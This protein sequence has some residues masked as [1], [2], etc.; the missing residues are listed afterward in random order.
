MDVFELLEL[1]VIRRVLATFLQPGDWDTAAAACL[2]F[3]SIA[4]VHNTGFYFPGNIP[5]SSY[6]FQIH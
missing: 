1:I 5:A 4:R 6:T 3:S 2:H